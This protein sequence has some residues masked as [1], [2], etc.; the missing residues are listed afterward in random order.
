MLYT[1]NNY[2]IN[3]KNIAQFFMHL[4]FL[5]HNNSQINFHLFV[6]ISK[7]Y[8]FSLFSL[9]DLYSFWCNVCILFMHCENINL[10]GGYC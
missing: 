8:I 4:I 9:D 5:G 2:L 3:N 7:N 10:E 6:D 1:S